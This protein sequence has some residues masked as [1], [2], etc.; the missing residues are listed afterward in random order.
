[1]EAYL[2]NWLTHKRG[3]RAFYAPPEAAWIHVEDFLSQQEATH[4]KEVLLASIPWKQEYIH[5]FGKKVAQPRL[6]AWHGEPE[7]SY[8]YSGLKLPPQ[9][10]TPELLSLKKKVADFCKAQFNSVLINLYREGADSMGWHSDDEKEL[11]QQ[12]VIASI[13]LGAERRFQFKHKYRK[14]IPLISFS[15]KSGSL[16]VMKGLTQQY[17]KHQVPK[18]KKLVEP[19]LNLTFRYIVSTS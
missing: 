16:F 1:M 8:T 19:R 17:W 14:E 18:T 12:P 6:T 13:S 11:G 3:N 2:K 10:W 15:L 4:M 7:A 5:L 9:P